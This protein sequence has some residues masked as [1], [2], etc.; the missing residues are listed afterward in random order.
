M[1]NKVILTG[2]LTNQPEL[3][4]TATDVSVASF[5]IAVQRQYKGADGNYPTNFLNCVAW[6]GTA[7]FICNHFGKGSLIG[8]VGSLQSRNYEDKQGNKRTAY[9]VIV[10]DVHFLESKAEKKIDP[11]FKAPASVDEFEDVQSD[12]L[13]F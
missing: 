8:I 10:E 2:R 12:E 13:P 3:N 1:I 9:E 6:R 5:G 4:K 11:E 7:D